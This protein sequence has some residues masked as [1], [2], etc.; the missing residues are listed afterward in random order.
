[1]AIH[2]SILAWKIPW[3]PL[4]SLINRPGLQSVLPYLR[5]YLAKVKNFRTY[6]SAQ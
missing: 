4:Y 6:S 1:M 3:M 5:M 2:S